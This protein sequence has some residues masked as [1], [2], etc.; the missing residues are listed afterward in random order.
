MSMKKKDLQ[1]QSDFYNGQLANARARVALILSI[2]EDPE[3]ELVKAQDLVDY[4]DNRFQ[5]LRIIKEKK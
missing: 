1:K 3:K 2:M 4:L 5:V